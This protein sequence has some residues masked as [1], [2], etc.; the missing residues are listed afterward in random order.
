MDTPKELE[1][2]LSNI[3]NFTSEISQLDNHRQNIQES[4]NK[5]GNSI[6]NSSHP[7]DEMAINL[8]AASKN[9]NDLKVS[10]VIGGA[11]LIVKG[12]GKLVKGF[13]YAYSE[14][15]VYQKEKKIKQKKIEIATLKINQ[16]SKTLIWAEKNFERV[17]KVFEKDLSVVVTDYEHDKLLYYPGRKNSFEL[18]F[19]SLFLLKA[20]KYV[21]DAYT[22]WLEHGGEEYYRLPPESSKILSELITMEGGIIGKFSKEEFTKLLLT[23][24]VKSNVMLVLENVY[25]INHLP[26]SLYELVKIE[27]KMPKQSPLRMALK[28]N[29]EY[30]N[31]TKKIFKNRIFF[32]ISCLLNLVNILLLYFWNTFGW[33]NL[34]IVP[35][36]ILLFVVA[37]L[38]RLDR[39][40]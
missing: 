29:E 25:L 26:L 18:Y 11:S 37:Y 24:V 38:I 40:L 35:L 28:N 30:K 9:K 33:W 32:V 1:Y 34:L 2:Y 13:G 7:I 36:N 10:A 12:V 3:S 8:L 4:W 27:K 15:K 16:A 14:Y 39:E 31:E 20:S 22:H 6:S 5:I 21:I 23:P 19:K 17:F